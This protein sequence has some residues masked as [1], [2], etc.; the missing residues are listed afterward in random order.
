QEI[1]F[2]VAL[3]YR[4]SNKTDLLSIKEI[5]YLLPANVLK[6]KDIHPQQWTTAIHDKFNSSVAMMSTIEAKMKFL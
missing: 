5:K 2:M 3:Q 4:A 6:L 1:S